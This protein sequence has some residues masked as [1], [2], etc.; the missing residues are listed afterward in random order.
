VEHFVKKF[1][2]LFCIVTVS[3]YLVSKT[4]LNVLLLKSLYERE[5]FLNV[6]RGTFLDNPWLG[7]GAG[8]FVSTLSVLNNI[9]SWQFQP[10]HNVFLLIL[11]EFGI[12]VFLGFLFFLIKMFHVE[13]SVKQAWSNLK[14]IPDKANELNA[15][16]KAILIAFTFIMLFDHY[17]WDI[18]QGQIM[19]WMVFAMIIFCKKNCICHKKENVS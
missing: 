10:V 14:N 12:F 8:Q 17:L 1:F 2:L 5:F 6:S 19:L 3:F 13:H 11:N 15:Y 9:E 7:I 16:F 4:D 18:Q